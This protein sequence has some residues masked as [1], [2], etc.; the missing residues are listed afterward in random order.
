MTQT[1]DANYREAIDRARQDEFGAFISVVGDE[2]AGRIAAAAADAHSPVAGMP[3]AVKDNIDTVDLPTTANTPALAGSIPAADQGAVARLAAAGALLVGKTNLHELA[4]GITTGAASVPATRNPHDPSRSPGGSS[5]GSA[6]A[7]ASGIVPFALATDT[8]GSA[9][10]PAAWCGV[11]GYRP[12][13]GRW[14]SGGTVPLSAT[15][16]TVGV[17]ARSLQ[18]VRDV[19]AIVREPGADTAGTVGV[20]AGVAGIVAAAADAAAG[21]PAPI[22][23]GVPLPDSRFLDP[24]ADDVSAQWRSTIDSLSAAPG[25]ELVPVATDLLHELDEA[26]GIGIVLYETARDLTA[27]LAALPKPVSYQQVQDQAAA[28]D[29]P[30]LLAAAAG[31]REAHDAYAELMAVRDRLI[32][33]WAAVFDDNDI[34]VLLRPTTPIT[35]VPVGDEF[36]TQAFGEEVPTF[37]TVIR[38]TGPGSTTGQ[39]SL[40]L[41]TGLG[42]AG[43]PVGISLDGRRGD[44]DTVFAVAAAIDGLLRG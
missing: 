44:D 18:L 13:M 11:Y 22:R 20:V 28:V 30:G 1:P 3:Y 7:V 5:G 17:I 4:F 23:I 27:Y 25:I 9:T 8:G 34:A 12:S 35:A 15:R 21:A 43:L 29:V 36:A 40:T 31:Q 16:D 24:L 37:P 42:S 33:A 2:L 19:D 32:A 41:P 26:C 38:N 39:P 14:P 6:A 10:V